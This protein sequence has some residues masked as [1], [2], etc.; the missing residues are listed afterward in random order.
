LEIFRKQQEEADKKARGTEAVENEETIGEEETWV[1]GG[2]KRKRTKDKEG[3]KGVKLRRSS[4]AE[5]S[6]VVDAS[7]TI[8]ATSVSKNQEV[9]T[10]PVV[11]GKKP[12]KP[13]EAVESKSKPAS[14][15]KKPPAKG[16]LVDYGSDEDDDW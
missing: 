15:T 7:P 2:R 9:S 3:L 16:G 13:E 6:K 12:V 1:A 11:E 4:T 8:V 14:D 10:A 5:T